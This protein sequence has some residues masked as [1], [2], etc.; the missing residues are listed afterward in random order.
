MAGTQTP[1][2]CSAASTT[3][4]TSTP[5]DHDRKLPLFDT[6]SAHAHLDLVEVP[7]FAPEPKPASL[8]SYLAE[9]LQAPYTTPFLLT[10]TF[11][12]AIL[13]S[14]TYNRFATFASNQTGNTVFLALAAVHAGQRKLKLTVTSF[15]GFVGSGLLFGQIG[16][17]FGE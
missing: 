8:H 9:T 1:S 4:A 13:D 12:T 11:S 3:T 5:G 16:A 6:T 14:M 7:D 2:S 17:Y 10:I 15:A